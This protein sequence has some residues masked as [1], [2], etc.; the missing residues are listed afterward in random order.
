[1]K[2]FRVPVLYTCIL[3]CSLCSFAQHQPIPLN[4]PDYNKPKLFQH[5]PD[6]ISVN[7]A[8]LI[9]LLN[10]PL[11]QSVNI[12][13]SD[14]SS[15]LFQ[16]KVISFA[17]KYDNKIQTVVLRSTNYNGASLTFS[18]ITRSNGT[19]TYTGRLLSFQHGDLYEL[20]EQG[21]GMVLMKKNFYDLVNE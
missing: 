14:N 15:F 21:A 16:G 20:K 18:R 7:L 4:E 2:N 8:V 13:L 19:I 6:N 5:L 12:N 9:G 3:F 10:S 17:S 1:M 11:G